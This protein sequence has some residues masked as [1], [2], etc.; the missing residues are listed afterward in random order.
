MYAIGMKHSLFMFARA[1]GLYALMIIRAHLEEFNY[2]ELYTSY[3][4][5]TL[6]CQRRS[7]RSSAC[8][9][10]ARA[11]VSLC[12][13]FSTPFVLSSYPF[14]LHIIFDTIDHFCSD[15]SCIHRF[16]QKAVY[17]TANKGH[18]RVV[19]PHTLLDYFSAG[20]FGG[21]G[22]GND[23]ILKRENVSKEGG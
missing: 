5:G 15:Y 14:C 23:Q 3:K 12:F 9:S 21:G 6:Q 7:S 22:G 16:E 13:T 18:F 1:T 2:N 8:H 17:M 4:S 20:G 10:F 11:L 19:Y